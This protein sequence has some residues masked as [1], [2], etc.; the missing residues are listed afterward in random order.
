MSN[1]IEVEGID[2]FDDKVIPAFQAPQHLDIYDIRAAS[3]EVRLSITALVGLINRP[4]P[5][6]YL[7]TDGDDAFWLKEVLSDI[8]QDVSPI[9]GNAIL[10]ALLSTYRTR[11]QG[12]IIYDP[13]FSDSI[14]IAT[15]LAGQQNGIVVSP[16]QVE[17]LRQDFEQIPILADLRAYKWRSRLQAYQWAQKH[18]LSNASLHLVTG[19]N[20]MA[21]PSL[22]SFLVATRSFIYWLD[23]RNILPDPRFGWLSEY[24]LMRGILRAFASGTAHLGWFI[25]EGTGVSVASRAAK[26]VFASDFFSNLEVWTSISPATPLPKQTSENQ[27]QSV[28]GPKVYISFTLSEGDNLQY[29]QHHMA[30][31]WRDPARGSVPIGWTISPVLLQAA[32]RMAAYYMNTATTHDEL[33]AGPSGGGYIYP[34]C[35]PTQHLPAFLQ[36]TSQL[37]QGMNLTVLEVLDSN[38]L[39]SIRLFLR[40]LLTGSGMALIKRDLQQRFVQA[41]SPLGLRGIL[42]GS[43]QSQASWRVIAEVPVYQNLG[44]A[45]SVSETISLIKNAASANQ[46]RPCFLN[47]YIL[48][49]TMTPS[50][51]KQVVQQLGDEY[52]AVTPGTLLAMLATRP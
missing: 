24:W 47:V 8:P 20:P 18:L 45:K 41:L 1:A 50:D 38:I 28:I 31:L 14:N 12:L 10:D 27:A 26:P 21:T 17:K 19:L 11:V 46:Q 5:Q 2:W 51:L 48:A 36:R 15:M 40:A 34:S 37:M 4:R 9:T 29:N 25:N 33:I 22:R 42:S 3:P 39:Q 52:E 23:S 13:D 16:G 43:G 30:R 6:V 32:P 35:W 44:I 49:W 7:I